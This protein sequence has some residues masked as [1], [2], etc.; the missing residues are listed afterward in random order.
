MSPKALLHGL[1][2]WVVFL[3][4]DKNLFVISHSCQRFQVLA[5][6]WIFYRIHLEFLNLL[7]GLYLLFRMP[8]HREGWC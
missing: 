4:C 3:I 8:L 7:L 5:Q 1:A 6:K 2:F